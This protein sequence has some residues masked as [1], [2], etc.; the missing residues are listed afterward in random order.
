MKHLRKTLLLTFVGLVLVVLIFPLSAF[1]AATTYTKTGYV[2]PDLIGLGAS[3][4]ISWNVSGSEI[5]NIL[6]SQKGGSF[7]GLINIKPNGY[8]LKSTNVIRTEWSLTIS[9]PF[10]IF[11]LEKGLYKKI[12]EYELK[13]DGKISMK[14]ISFKKTY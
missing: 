12:V 7:L 13:T 3:D 10:K 2:F 8:Y 6:V 14:I 1:S 5:K 11:N 9:A 4:K